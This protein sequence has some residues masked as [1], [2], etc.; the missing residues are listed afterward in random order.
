MQ[1]K[2][3]VD[4][5]TASQVDQCWDKVAGDGYQVSSLEDNL[6]SS[7]P[8]TQLA[9]N[10]VSLS[11][12]SLVN[13]QYYADSRKTIQSYVSAESAH[14]LYGFGVPTLST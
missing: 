2:C 8:T 5:V 14:A 1:V 7:A 3:A 13:D 12:T 9:Y 6:P 10:A 4:N 11:A